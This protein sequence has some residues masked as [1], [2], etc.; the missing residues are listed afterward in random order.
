MFPSFWFR[1]AL[2]LVYVGKWCPFN[3]RSKVLGWG[4]ATLLC[5]A[6]SHS[7]MFFFFGREKESTP[8]HFFEIDAKPVLAQFFINIPCCAFPSPELYLLSMGHVIIYAFFSFS[9]TV[10]FLS[11]PPIH[12]LGLGTR[13]LAIW[14][15]WKCRK[16]GDSNHVLIH[17]WW[18]L[19]L[20]VKN[21]NL[22]WMAYLPCGL[23]G[24]GGFGFM[25]KRF[26][27]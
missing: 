3:V 13:I 25:D 14:A 16:L 19:C 1:Y 8:R 18:L 12:W 26:F 27:T 22:L 4:K 23:F 24:W 7:S 9:L 5:V 11:P 6:Y 15:D 17:R 10:Q 20:C 21:Q 2:L